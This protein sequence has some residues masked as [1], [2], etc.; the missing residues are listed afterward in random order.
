MSNVQIP[1]LP[2]AIAL[3]GAEQLEAVQAGT[4]VRVTANQLR[5]YFSLSLAVGGTAIANGSTG[6]LLYDNGGFLGEL[7][8]GIVTSKTANYTISAAD[9]YRDFDNNGAAGQV[10]FTLPAATVGLAYGF[11]VLEAQ[12][13]IVS[14]PGGVVIYLGGLATSAGGNITS[15]TVGSYLSLKCRSAT[16]WMVQ[17]SMGSWT[18]S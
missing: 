9:N 8:F 6:N 10:T 7:P 1:N 14:A 17:S 13:L 4:S 12:N 3:N 2:A 16:E 11:A 5:T 18:P 15:N